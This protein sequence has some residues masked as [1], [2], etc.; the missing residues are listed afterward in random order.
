MDKVCHRTQLHI[1][2]YAVDNTAPDWTFVWDEPWGYC[3]L[4]GMTW[5]ESDT[6]M[7]FYPFDY[8][9]EDEGCLGGVGV[10]LGGVQFRI[11]FPGINPENG[12][13]TEW[14]S[15]NG[16]FT[17]A[18]PWLVELYPGIEAESE[19]IVE[20][21][22]VDR[23]CNAQEV[24]SFTFQI[25]NADPI[26]DILNPHPDWYYR[27]GHIID[28]M[29]AD[30]TGDDIIAFQWFWSYDGV[31]WN[32]IWE[33]EGSVE[34]EVTWDTVVIDDPKCEEG[35]RKVYVMLKVYDE[36]CR[37]GEVIEE[38]WF[39]KAE[40]PHPCVQTITIGEGW[41]LISF[42]VEMDSFSEIAPEGYTASILAAEINSQAGDAIVKYIV[43]WDADAGEFNEYVVDSGIGWDFPINQ[44]EGYYVFSVSPFEVDFV[45]VGDC[46]ECEYFYLDVC[47]NLIGWNSWES[48]WVGEF[49]DLINAAA[50]ADVVQAIV[51][52]DYDD[53]YE[54]Y[55]PGGDEFMFKMSADHAYWV[56]VSQPV[57]PIWF[58]DVGIIIPP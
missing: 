15:Y 27:P 23:V 12:D 2:T 52:H 14:F 21:R 47:W 35:P 31:T 25:D 28:L 48:M 53:V 54:P 45:I 4:F 49:E 36:H 9:T 58:D 43:R 10:A 37:W 38:I 11:H 34:K 29:F 26:P 55:Y 57:G 6:Q 44:G 7:G 19:H 8:I 56:F 40:N 41:N 1:Q 30:L 24:Q 42:A 18:D 3:E 20:W 16:F 50:G 22:A 32:L 51:R 5:W 17:I 46:A 39:C 33:G 13:W